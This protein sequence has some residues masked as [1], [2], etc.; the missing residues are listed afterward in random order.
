MKKIAFTGGGSAGHVVPNLSLISEILASG[1]ADVC[2]FGSNGIEKSLV[3]RLRIPYYQTECPKL[4]RG[5]SFSALRKNLK[6]PCLLK[7]A[8][9]HAEIGLKTFA[10]DV[11][12]SKGGYVALPVVLAARRLKIPCLTHESDFSPGLAN[13]LIA[14]KCERV[15]TSFPETADKFKNGKYT[16]APVRREL[17]GYSKAESARK[18]SAPTDKKTLLVFGGGSGSAAINEALRES[19]PTL[20]KKYFVLH[21]CGKG[22][23]V[24]SNLKNY[25]QEEFVADMGAAYALSDMV[26]ARAGAGTVF[27]ILALKKPA[28]LIPLEGQTRGD[29]KENARYFEKK[30]LCRVLKQSELYRLE[31]AIDECFSDEGL[32]ERL[33]VSDF[34]CGNSNILHEIRKFL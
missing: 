17:F 19:L 33:A 8:V 18:F 27:E 22:N 23:V 25:R 29:Q 10:P 20:C 4:V 34:V 11:V 3:E 9:K 1:E 31:A 12:F 7:K 14:K 16:G 32:K 24:E 13:K 5:K 2:Y 26:I 28:L 30:G 21:I 15:L 6:I